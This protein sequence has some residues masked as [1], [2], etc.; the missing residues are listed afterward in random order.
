[1]KPIP[2]IFTRQARGF[3]FVTAIF[4]LLIL[5]AFAAFVVNFVT[6]AHATTALAVQG[7]R[8]YEVARAGIE[9]ATYQVRLEV[10]SAASG[11]INLPACFGSPAS[12]ALPAAFTDFN[13]QV[14]CQRYPATGAVPEFHEEGARRVVIYVLTAT[15]TSG[16]V[17]ASDYVERRLEARIEKCKDPDASAPLYGCL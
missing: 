12:P 3:A 11:T 14:N 2:T 9:W 13:V 4:L 1:M 7:A 15:A 10:A 8:A 6:H 5:G 16:T 17:G